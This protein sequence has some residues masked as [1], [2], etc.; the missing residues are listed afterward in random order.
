[1]APLAQLLTR[2]PLSL[3]AHLTSYVPGETPLSTNPAVWKT[4][5]AYLVVTFGLKSVMRY[6]R[7]FKLFLLFQ[8]H[9][10]VLSISSLLL[11]ILML[12][13]LAPLAWKNGIFSVGCVA[14]LTW[15]PRMEFYQLINYYLKYLHLLDTVFLSLKKKPIQFLHIFHHSGSALLGYYHLN[16]QP[17]RRAA[18]S[19]I[20]VTLNLAEHV[21]MYYYYYVTSN[22]VKIWWKKHLTF[23]QIA[24][25]MIDIVVICHGLYSHMAA[26]YF[27]DT[28]PYL[29][30][31]DV[32]DLNIAISSVALL[33]GYLILFLN[34]YLRTYNEVSVRLG[35]SERKWPAGT[36]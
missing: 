30:D 15:T 32:G 3:P 33:S 16:T 36:N 8:T 1:M 7:P 27:P 18:G 19:W 23:V 2:I 22:G 35:R 29:D 9:N 4:I 5:T 20:I 34:F 31:C 12:E 14:S 24:Q 26:T 28:L 10:I 13:E 11:L 25:F 17:S 21:V 6:R